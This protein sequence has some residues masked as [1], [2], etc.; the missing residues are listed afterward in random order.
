MTRTEAERFVD[1][2]AD[3]LH[4]HDAMLHFE[5]GKL[6]VRN[7]AGDSMVVSAFGPDGEGGYA[8]DCRNWCSE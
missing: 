7:A 5:D 8:I 2:L 3:L 6:S 4:K 1:A